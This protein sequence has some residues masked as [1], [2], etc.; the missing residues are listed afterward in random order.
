[1]KTKAKVAAAF[2]TVMSLLAGALAL[3]GLGVFA[4]MGLSR[5]R[6]VYPEVRGGVGKAV[7]FLVASPINNRGPHGERGEE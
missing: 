5:W 1:M 6:A 4:W 2:V 7:E 3:A